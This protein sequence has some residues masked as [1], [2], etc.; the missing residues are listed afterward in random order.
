MAQ[1]TE[2]SQDTTVLADVKYLL[3]I[4]SKILQRLFI[5]FHQRPEIRERKKNIKRACVL[6]ESYLCRPGQV[7]PLKVHEIFPKIKMSLLGYIL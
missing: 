7:L 2:E 4:L 6:Y 1:D 5:G 3:K